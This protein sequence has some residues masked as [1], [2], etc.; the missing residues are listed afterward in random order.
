MKVRRG[1]TKVKR[2]LTKVREK[3]VLLACFLI[4]IGFAAAQTSTVSGVVTSGE[5]NEPVIGASVLVVGHSLGTVTDIDGRFSIANV[6]SAA[7]T[8]RVSYVGMQPQEVAIKSGEIKIILTP[9]S[10]MLDEVVVT[11]MGISRAKKALGYAVAE[12]S[13]DEMQKTRG[14]VSNPVNAL[15]GKVAG[16][17]ISSG[18]GSMGGSSKIL[19]RGVSSI[20]GN[21]QPLFVIDGVPIEG[22]DFNSKTTQRGAGGYDYG[23]LVQDINQDDIETISVLK[24]A[25]ASA[26]YG[27]RANNGVVMIT[28]KKGKKDEG[29]GVSFT[30]SVGF[31]VVNKLPKLQKEYGGGAGTEFEQVT[32]NGVTYNYPDYNTD[33]SWG[34]KLEGQ[35]VLS[36][37]DLAKWEANGKKG[38]PTTS[39][40][41]APEHDVDSFFETGVSFTNNVSISQATDR[42]SMRISYTN[43]DLKGY[44]PNSSMT[45]NAFSISG[46]TT[47]ADKKLEA[48]TNITYLNSR[49]KGRTETG[50]GNNN[51]MVKFVQWGHR[52]LDMLQLKDLYIM[53]DGT[54]ASWNR[55]AWDDPTPAYSNNPYWSRYMNYQNDVRNRIYGNV[56]VSYQIIPQLK[57]QYKANL[58]FFVDKQYERNAVGSQE[59]SA[60]KEISRQQYE[61][62]HEFMLM[63]NQTF[64]DYSLNA[65]L[66]G[67]IMKSRYEY[68][69]G[70]TEGGLSLPLYY[71]LAN[72]ISTAS[73]YNYLRKKAIY[74]AFANVSAGWRSMVYLEATLRNDRSST[75]PSGNNSY[76]YPSLTASFIFSELLK[77]KA[78]W[79]SFGK[80]RLGWA[81]VGN[82]TDPYQ[83]LSTYSQY[84]NIDSAAPGYVL[85]NT[86]N[87]DRLKPESTV[88]YEIGLEMSFFNNRLGFDATYY[89][90][91]TKDQIIPLPVSGTTGYL[92]QIINSGVISNKGVE[93]ALH[94]TPVQTRKFSWTTS[95][96][97]SSN[98]NKVKELVDGVDYYKISAAP[99]IVEIGA[100][101]G[102][103]YGVIMGTDY[104]YDANGNK[105][106]D[107]D[108]GLYESTDGNENLGSIYPDFT[109]GWSNTFRFG[110]LDLSI[111]LDFSKG[112]HYF[113]TSY[114]YG[115]YSG[116]LEETAA[117]NIRENGILLDGVTDENGTRNTTVAGG[118]AYCEHYYSGPAAQSVLKS[119]YVKLREISV[120]YTVPLNRNAFVKSLKVSAYGRNLA[121]WGPDTKHF[122]PEM[123]VTGSGNIQGV[124]G[125]AIPSVA[126]FGASVS[127]KF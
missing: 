47:S 16:L 103:S 69:Y 7:K 118:Q 17:Q 68:V 40:W 3:L 109:G 113:S 110:N 106:I 122:D 87:N 62:N 8:L 95:L 58:D 66:G 23:N 91:E 125:G 74:S 92:Y 52:E 33:Q 24:G 72:S 59:Q 12:V 111:L 119:D 39:L 81:N 4:N 75:L 98:K 116:M 22:G 11:A 67:N 42:A 38:N 61:L 70:K 30:T 101:K 89:T 34:P 65:N 28:T 50:Y 36:W 85:S 60:Y 54:Q 86:C 2:E 35:E 49:A 126:N 83:V 43:T 18:S 121:V 27:S 115:M 1:F 99:F 108:T 78:S 14:G 104:V 64:G 123:I 41:T 84:S 94:A 25:S 46:T 73:A 76:W 114:M 79:I 56:G 45:K 112:G 10:E 48:F 88:S 31:E 82:D 19:I 105:M 20:S 93:F 57:A 15:Q 90:S 124:E 80:L 13:G 107:P 71:N 51:V 32:I 102:E 127:L 117:G 5:D 120:G 29:L 37:Y 44:M 100:M 9:D 97:L 26:L 6:P 77:E 96:T 21:N 53:P 63:Y 55:T